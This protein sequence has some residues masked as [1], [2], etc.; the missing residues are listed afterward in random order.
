LIILG[1]DIDNSSKELFTLLK[2]YANMKMAQHQH[3]TGA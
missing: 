2:E 3:K 1:A